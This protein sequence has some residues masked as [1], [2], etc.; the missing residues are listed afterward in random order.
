MKFVFAGSLDNSYVLAA[1]KTPNFIKNKSPLPA[2]AVSDQERDFA[3]IRKK[4]EI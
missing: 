4:K 1:E 2:D 3:F